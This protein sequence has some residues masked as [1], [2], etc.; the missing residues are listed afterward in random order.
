MPKRKRRRSPSY[1][2]L[3]KA[4]GLFRLAR[5]DIPRDNHMRADSDHTCNNKLKN[6]EQDAA[7]GRVPELRKELA[8]VI[9]VFQRNHRKA[10]KI[11]R[12]DFQE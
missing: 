7:Y 5:L 12:L 9:M 10:T 8:G 3:D 6:Q 11:K 4:P 2:D 1:E